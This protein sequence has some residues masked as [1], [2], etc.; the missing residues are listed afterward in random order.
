MTDQNV[1][2]L[3]DSVMTRADA[4]LDSELESLK[5]QIKT[6][7]TE[8]EQLREEKEALQTEL[9]KTTRGTLQLASELEE[10]YQRLFETAVEGIYVTTDTLDEYVLANPAFAD[11]LGYENG[12]EL[13]EN[14]DS[15]ADE[16]FVDENQYTTYS[17][18]LHSDGELARFEYRVRTV[19]GET[20]WLSDSVTAFTNADDQ[21]QGYRGG[22]IDITNRIREQTRLTTLFENSSDAIVA[23]EFVDREPMIRAVNSAFVETFGYD[24]DSVVGE[25]FVD[26]LIPS[27]RIDEFSN[28]TDRI[29]SG[30]HITTEVRRETKNGPREFLLR[31][32]PVEQEERVSD[33]YAVYTDITERK[34]REQQ[35]TVLNRILRH[36]LRNDMNLVQGY[37][38][39]LAE[40]VTEPETTNAAHEIEEKAAELI[41]L[42]QKANH[43]QK[44]SQRTGSNQQVDVANIVE[45]V[46]ETIQKTRPEVEIETQ[47]AES[48]VTPGPAQ[49][50]VAIRELC[51]NA[52][53]YTTDRTPKVKIRITSSD[54]PPGYIEV[55]VRDN[56]PGIPDNE[57]A[58]LADGDET[59]LRHGSGLGLWMVNWIVSSVGGEVD[60]TDN[61]SRGSVVRIT[62]PTAS[63]RG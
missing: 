48:P 16:I 7:Q 32:V 60:I 34:Q 53:K 55:Q 61:V 14:V 44:L 17:D 8:N 49:L 4:E 62:L 26:I 40:E 11:L 46:A 43:I 36:N 1:E 58:V 21:I 33:A 50:D 24:V 51:D 38:S 27:D 31:G 13:C 42:S 25:S 6:L 20:R 9:E 35:L 39:Y 18:T 5:H 10:R 54:A 30:E 28:H 23:V 63:D 19:N 12:E 52:I 15:I 45:D 29:L 2:Q 3:L 59:P 56:G 57:R 41:D 22:C 47:L 37:A